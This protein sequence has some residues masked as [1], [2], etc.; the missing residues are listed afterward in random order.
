METLIAVYVFC[1][2]L[3]VGS[4][5]NVCIWRLP[6]EESVVKPRS[7]CPQCSA[8]IAWYDNI[9][10]LSFVLL[11]GRC[12]HCS[13]RVSWRYPAVEL[14]N[15]LLWLATYQLFG[16]QPVTLVYMALISACIA[17]TWIDWEHQIIPDEISLGGLVL[18]LLLSALLPQL[19]GASSVSSSLLRS[20]M[21]ILA[22]G[23]SLYLIGVIGEIIYRKEAMGGGDVK[24]LAM[25]GSLLGWQGVILIFF[26]APLFGSV[27]GLI[28]R[29]KMKT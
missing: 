23:G 27:V 4:F 13:A 19:H 18:G 9:P 12:R 11:K 16:L 28:M 25:V 5:L 21:G 10:I 17:V 26:L 7:H 1:F 14:L 6:R 3:L 8:T 2:G 29:F 20:M 15:G 24:F 22:G